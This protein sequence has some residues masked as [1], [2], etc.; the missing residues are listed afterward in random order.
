MKVSVRKLLSI[1]CAFVLILTLTTGI[2]EKGFADDYDETNNDNEAVA[3]VTINSTTT[4]HK[5]LK[6]A[7]NKAKAAS[8]VVTVEILKDIE[9]GSE[10]WTSISNFSKNIWSTTSKSIL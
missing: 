2:I 9:L 8:A 6:G 5:T 3:S 7:M 4:K 1:L 10:G